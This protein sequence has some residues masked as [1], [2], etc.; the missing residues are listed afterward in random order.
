[1]VFIF[2]WSRKNKQYIYD[3]D[4]LYAIVYKQTKI[5]YAIRSVY[6]CVHSTI[7]IW[8]IAMLIIIMIIDEFETLDSLII[9]GHACGQIGMYIFSPLFFSHELKAKQIRRQVH[10]FQQWIMQIG[11]FFYILVLY[12]LYLLPATP[13]WLVKC[14]G[15]TSGLVDKCVNKNSSLWASH[16][17]TPRIGS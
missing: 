15:S 7:R 6:G 3:G 11:D 13:T 10:L 14:G 8:I 2:R 12:I 5:V 9:I 17:S 16:R 1:M 4:T